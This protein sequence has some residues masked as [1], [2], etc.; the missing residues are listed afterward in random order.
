MIGGDG[1]D[2]LI[3]NGIVNLMFGDSF[4]IG[5]ELAY[6]LNVKKTLQDI[7][8]GAGIVPSVWNNSK[9]VPTWPGLTGNGNDIITAGNNASPLLNIVFGGDGNDTITTNALLANLVFA[10]NGDDSIDASGSRGFSAILGGNDD[11]TIK[12]SKNSSNVLFGDTISM[13]FP[14]GLDLEELTHGVLS[15][16]APMTPTGVGNDTIIGGD[17]LLDLIIGG[18]GDDTIRGGDGTFNLVFGDGL[19]V[20]T[21]S[22]FDLS[23]LRRYLWVE[24]DP[25][26]LLVLLQQQ[27]VLQG[28]G[29][30][31]IEGGTAWDIVIAGE[32]DDHVC[33]GASWDAIYGNAGDDMLCGGNGDDYLVGGTG[34]DCIDGQLST[35]AHY[36]NKGADGFNFNTADERL[37]NNDFDPAEDQLGCNR[38][39]PLAFSKDP[40]DDGDVVILTGGFSGS[41]QAGTV[42]IDWGDGNTEIRPR[43]A[44]HVDHIYKDDRPTGEQDEY[45][46]VVTDNSTNE[47]LDRTTIQVHNVA[48]QVSSV[49]AAPTAYV[50]RPLTY[51]SEFIEPGVL[52]PLT[53]NFDW[54][55]TKTSNYNYPA[56]TTSFSVQHTYTSPGRFFVIFTLS[57]DD[58]GSK[59]YYM[60]V[61]VTEPWFGGGEGEAAPV[62]RADFADLL[63]NVQQIGMKGATNRLGTT[64]RPHVPEPC[65]PLMLRPDEVG[66]RRVSETLLSV[67][68][69]DHFHERVGPWQN[70]S[71]AELLAQLDDASL[72]DWLEDTVDDDL[73]VR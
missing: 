67:L 21:G 52:D 14:A 9:I 47:E 37:E 5:V 63:S 17:G 64:D 23:L 29:D 26:R 4:N 6:E 61:E 68:A 1:K 41:C 55:D 39:I 42:E 40:A 20:R 44:F 70:D 12:G 33:G 8:N 56:G 59:T 31:D 22:R 15:F 73:K 51:S 19:G 38:Q 71:H 54:G 45:T 11:D 58:E 25:E 2:T 49:F 16:S 62:F 69:D 34:D 24:W 43:W 28:P 72:T 65:R 53:M 13:A 35:D 3:G 36:G 46:V 32:G 57:D 27:F 18:D 50:N 48:P 30:D 66:P 7:Q 10:N 60:T